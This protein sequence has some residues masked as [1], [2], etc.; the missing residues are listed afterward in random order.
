MH[1]R[2]D[3]QGL[4][5]V[6]AGRQRLCRVLLLAG[7]ARVRVSVQDAEKVVDKSG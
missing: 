1:G 7:G 6:L 3:R 2:K 5:R 4:P